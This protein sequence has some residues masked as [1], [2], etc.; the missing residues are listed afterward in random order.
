MPAYPP[1]LAAVSVANKAVAWPGMNPSS[2]ARLHTSANEKINASG[3]FCVDMHFK[4][5]GLW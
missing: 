3:L 2:I 1:R 4:T 5:V